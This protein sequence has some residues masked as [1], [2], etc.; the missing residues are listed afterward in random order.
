VQGSGLGTYTVSVDRTS[1]AIGTYTANIQFT[2]V[3]DPNPV[4]V[5]VTVQKVDN[6]VDPTANAGF[7]YAVLVNADDLS[8]QDTVTASFANGVYSYQFYSTPPGT[9]KIYA[10]TDSDNDSMICDAGEACGAYATTDQPL[11]I[12]VESTPLSGLDFSSGFSTN[13][14]IA[15]ASV[16]SRKPL[17]ITKAL[18]KDVANVR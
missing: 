5:S 15:A 11:T 10:G 1:L 13:L 14:G 18:H 6:S 9:Y 16:V 17:T 4:N 7:H 3:E 8:T 2:A 12:T